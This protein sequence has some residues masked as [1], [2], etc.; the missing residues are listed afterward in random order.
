ML[1]KIM[2]IDALKY[3]ATCKLIIITQVAVTLFKLMHDKYYPKL[4]RK[5]KLKSINTM[6]VYLV[7]QSNTIDE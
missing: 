1:T 2:V 5:Y 3:R 7:K 6:A 4:I